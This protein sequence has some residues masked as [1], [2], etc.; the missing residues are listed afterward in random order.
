MR[1]LIQLSVAA[2][3][4]FSAYAGSYVD[5]FRAVIR[6][7]AGEVRELV[8]RGFD[9]NARDEAGQPAIIRALQVDSYDAA[10]GLAK[11]PGLDVEALNK[12]GETPLMIAALKGQ[13]AVCEVLVARGAALN[14]P[15]WAPLH[16]AA[17]GNSLPVLRYLI[18]SGARLD[19]PAPNGR[20]ALMMAVMHSDEVLV[21]ALLA[22]GADTQARD[23][24]DITA[25]ELA[26]RAGRDRLA[27]RLTGLGK[28]TQ[29]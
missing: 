2:C 25:V 16:Y 29:R 15:G 8:A 21:D 11:L 7:D 23:R 13:L 26:R 3:V 27:A 19:A 6:D 28:T 18:K 9:P 24:N 12:A 10:L 20:T 17:S 14:R 4:S 22:A 1:F 5:F